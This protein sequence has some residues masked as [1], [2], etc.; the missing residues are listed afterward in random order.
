MSR[1]MAPVTCPQCHTRQEIDPDAE[2][3]RCL[4]CAATWSFVRCTVCG[5]RFHT[6]PGTRAWTCP[7][8]GTPHGRDRRGISRPGVPLP[9]LIGGIAVALAIVIGLILLFTGDEGGAPTP[10]TPSPSVIADPFRKVCR[11]LVDVQLLREDALDRASEALTADAA[12]LRARG[13]EESAAAVEA[14]V[15]A[16][17]SYQEVAAGGGDTVAATNQLLDALDAVDCSGAT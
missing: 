13:D 12:A 3:Y 7:N 11:D 8:C 17:G 9:L 15:D 14:I 1:P 16:I 5:Q 4:V 6:R 10:T 2:G